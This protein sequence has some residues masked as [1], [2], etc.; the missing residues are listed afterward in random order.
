MGCSMAEFRAGSQALRD[1][2]GPYKGKGKE[3]KIGNL[4]S[5]ALPA[6]GSMGLISAFR[7][8]WLFDKACFGFRLRR[9]LK[10]GST[11]LAWKTFG[12]SNPL[13]VLHSCFAA[14]FRYRWLLA[15]AAII[16]RKPQNVAKIEFFGN[17]GGIEKWEGLVVRGAF[18]NFVRVLRYAVFSRVQPG[19]RG[20]RTTGPGGKIL[21]RDSLCNGLYL[22]IV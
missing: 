12:F 9:V 21:F 8:P 13:S 3:W 7:H 1:S 17:F 22:L 2:A 16:H 20:G 15:S 14:A 19:G 5:A 11:A 6:S 18:W 4:P 10:S